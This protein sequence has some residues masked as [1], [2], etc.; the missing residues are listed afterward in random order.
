MKKH[1]T[2]SKLFWASFL[3]GFLPG[4]LGVPAYYVGETLSYL[5]HETKAQPDGTAFRIVNKDTQILSLEAANRIGSVN[6]YSANINEV[7]EKK[8]PSIMLDTYKGKYGRTWLKVTAYNHGNDADYIASARID[9]Y[10]RPENG[11]LAAV[12]T[13]LS[14]IIQAPVNNLHITINPS[15]MTADEKG[16]PKTLNIEKLGIHCTIDTTYSRDA[17]NG[18]FDRYAYKAVN[19]SCEHNYDMKFTDIY[20]APNLST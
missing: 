12:F 3:T 6:D 15:H 17:Y 19:M 14:D 8:A 4:Y 9:Y 10:D 13:A 11:N 20:T 2:L 16:I 5:S 1:I 7:L 18:A